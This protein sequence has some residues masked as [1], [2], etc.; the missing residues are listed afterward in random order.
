MTIKDDLNRKIDYLG[1][2]VLTSS[3]FSISLT[4]PSLLSG[5][6]GVLILKKLLFDHTG[7][8]RFKN[9]FTK[10][11]E[12]ICDQI[13]AEDKID[14]SF[15]N[16]IAG[17]GWTLLY[18][19]KTN[20]I[21]IDP[22]LFLTDIDDIL[23]IVLEKHI[24]SENFDLLHGAMGIGLYFIKRNLYSFVIPII[25]KLYEVSHK[26]NGEFKWSRYDSYIHKELIFDYGLAHGQAGVL[27]FLGKCYTHNICK[28]LCK[29]L[30]DGIINFYFNN[31]QEL[32]ENTS[33][34]PTSVLQKE[35]NKTYKAPNTS[36][37]AWCNGDLG[38]L[39][40]I[41]LIGTWIKDDN[42]IAK[43]EEMLI[44]IS[45]KRSSLITKIGDSQFCHGSSG[46]GYMYLNL[47]RMTGNP[48]FEETSD[49][50]IAETLKMGLNKNQGIGGYLFQIGESSAP[51][52][53]LLSGLSGVMI[54]LLSSANKNLDQ[55]WSECFF[56]N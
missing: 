38:I 10:D 50:W 14:Y 23:Q 28:D 5:N 25:E 53:D 42:L 12:L 3:I 27:Y 36:R 48:I 30:I 18:L 54:F 11:I 43:A 40:T 22:E 34:F 8:P 13:E 51:L 19:K 52:V 47:F 29:Q 46:V 20:D 15:C 31:I 56:L 16:G 1:N 37:I 7:D 21:N 33:F 55:D 45:K 35:Y 9:S 44:E 32:T 4:K 2:L 49:Y 39:H 17:L 24:N 41:Y 6:C 26:T